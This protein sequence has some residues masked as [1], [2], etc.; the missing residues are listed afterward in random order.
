MDLRFAGPFLLAFFV[1]AFFL[2]EAFLAEAFFFVPA[3]LL[4]LPLPKA[5]SQLSE[6]C[7]VVPLCKTVTT[8]PLCH[9]LNLTAI[10]VHLPH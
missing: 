9:I 3:E 6:Y 7:L 5:C 2:G 10:W 1:E 4:F 8:F